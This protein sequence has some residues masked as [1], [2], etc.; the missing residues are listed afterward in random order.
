MKTA[1]VYSLV[2]IC[3]INLWAYEPG[4]D[5]RLEAAIDKITSQNY[6]EADSLLRAIVQKDSSR[7]DALYLRLANHQTRIL[8]YESYALEENF[9]ISL[10]DSIQSVLFKM[11]EDK[12]GKDSLWCLFYIGSAKGGKSVIWGK[13]GKWLIAAREAVTSTRIFETIIELDSSF[14]AAY[15]GTGIFKYYLSQS[16]KWLPFVGTGKATE[17]INEIELATKAPPPYDL[18]A[19]NSLCWILIE[20]GKFKQAERMVDAILKRMPN[21]TIFLRIKANIAYNRK[22]WIDLNRAAE[23]LI[24]LSE[25]RSPVNWSDLVLGYEY[26]IYY[27][28]HHKR[29]RR[30]LSLSRRALSLAIPDTSRQIIYVKEHL[31]KIEQ[32]RLRYIREGNGEE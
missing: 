7:I 21:N 8:D 22:E 28:D 11:L 27:Y 24:E 19:K 18:A 12:Q 13:N 1:L 4:D 20:R 30:V 14:Y 25:K 2:F 29:R 3:L 16:F 31:K 32:V 17:G 9:F 10:C 6:K 23:K 26:L 5:E 15:L